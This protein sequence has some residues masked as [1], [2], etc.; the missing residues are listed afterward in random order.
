M[1]VNESGVL[2]VRIEALNAAGKL[3]ALDVVF[4]VKK[5]AP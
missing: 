2:N 1:L 4:P 3:Y 5:A